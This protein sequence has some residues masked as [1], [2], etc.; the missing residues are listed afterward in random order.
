MQPFDYSTPPP[1]SALN[2][3]PRKTVALVRMSVN[4]GGVGE[5]GMLSHSKSGTCDLLSYSL[6]ILAGQYEKRKVCGQFIAEPEDD[7]YGDQ[8][9]RGRKMRKKIL[10]SAFNLDS[11]D[12]SSEAKAT[13]TIGVAG[14][15][16]TRLAVGGAH[17]SPARSGRPADQDH[18]DVLLAQ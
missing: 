14:S 7:K 13:L 4:A 9:W 1:A 12:V 18:P 5:D 10:Q 15:A 8:V 16:P 2:L 11:N 17:D 6:T 3:I